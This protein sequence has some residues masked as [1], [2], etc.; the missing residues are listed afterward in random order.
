M[1]NGPDD[2]SHGEEASVR[3]R[4]VDRSIGIRIRARRE[5]VGLLAAELAQVMQLTEQQ[6]S[7]FEDGL[8]RPPPGI[9]FGLCAPL[10]CSIRFLFAGVDQS[11]ELPNLTAT[12]EDRPGA[13]PGDHG[14]AQLEIC[15]DIQEIVHVYGRLTVAERRTVLDFAQSLADG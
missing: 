14:A 13:S 9:L 1:A 11:L 5:Q 7:R 6:L 10:D 3:I 12:A 15:N 2:T 4:T 8:E